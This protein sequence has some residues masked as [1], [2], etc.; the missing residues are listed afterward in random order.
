[1]APALRGNGQN[2]DTKNVEYESHEH[3]DAALGQ[4]MRRLHRS[5]EEDGRGAVKSYRN[6]D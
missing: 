1:M 4:W 5:F 2:D 6:Y 3:D